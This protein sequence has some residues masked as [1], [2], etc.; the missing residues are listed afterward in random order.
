MAAISHGFEANM[1]NLQIGHKKIQKYQAV[2]LIFGKRVGMM[3]TRM[4]ISASN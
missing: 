4:K 2:Q 3:M 1:R